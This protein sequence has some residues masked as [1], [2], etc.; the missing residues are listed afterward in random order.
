MTLE[1]ILYRCELTYDTDD[2]SYVASYRPYLCNGFIILRVF[3]RVSKATIFQTPQTSTEMIGAMRQIAVISEWTPHI[4]S[5]QFIDH[6]QQ[7][8][9]APGPHL[10][11][12]S[13]T[14]VKSK[15]GDYR[16]QTAGYN[17]TNGDKNERFEPYRQHI[18]N[19]TTRQ[20]K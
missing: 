15:G 8:E 12:D 19:I 3:K 6:L 14:K 7:M 16:D 13:I 18:R 4:Y 10:Y 9:T 2:S 20:I 17:S 1:E 5:R 11:K